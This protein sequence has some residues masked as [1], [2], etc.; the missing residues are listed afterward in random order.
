MK[1][2]NLGLIAFNLISAANALSEILDYEFDENRLTVPYK[3]AAEL[4]VSVQQH[5]KSATDELIFLYEDQG[6]WQ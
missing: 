1:E 2:P 6:G 3:R 5:A 4:I